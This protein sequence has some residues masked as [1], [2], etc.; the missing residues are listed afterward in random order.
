M[1][2]LVLWKSDNN[3]NPNSNNSSSNNNN[4][5]NVRS[6]WDPFPGRKKRKSGSRPRSLLWTVELTE[7]SL[8][9]WESVRLALSW[10]PLLPVPSCLIRD[11]DGVTTDD[12]MSSSVSTRVDVSRRRS[13]VASRGW[14][15]HSAPVC[16]EE[17]LRTAGVLSPTTTPTT[18]KHCLRPSPIYT[19]VH[20]HHDTS[21]KL[22]FGYRVFQRNRSSTTVLPA[23]FSIF[24]GIFR[25]AKASRISR[26]TPALWSHLPLTRRISSTKFGQLILI[27]KTVKI[28]KR[29]K[30]YSDPFVLF[31]L[32]SKKTFSGTK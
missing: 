29:C 11:A 21:V 8:P 5:N 27:S 3:K 25:P 7:M 14:P 26:E 13:V 10:P 22:T 28:V 19:P 17:P 24:T 16:R 23:L 30:T 12:A 31:R 15:G 18:P 20:N 6:H 1:K 4:N 32:S 9:R 2:V